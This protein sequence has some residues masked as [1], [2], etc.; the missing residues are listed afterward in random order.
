MIEFIFPHRLHRL[1]YFLRG[2]VFDVIT[3]FLY[4]CSTT[5]NAKVWWASV[6]MLT[7]YGMFFIVLPRVRDIGMNGWWAL[8]MLV[9]V[10]NVVFAII[11]LFRA[12]VILSD[13]PNQALHATAAAPGC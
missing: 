13:R 8:V 5:I 6:T 1:A 7:I 9:P 4:S 12:P 3:G 2:V 10:A 11:L